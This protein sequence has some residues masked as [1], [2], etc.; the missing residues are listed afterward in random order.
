MPAKTKSP[1][2]HAAQNSTFRRSRSARWKIALISAKA[3]FCTSA[4]ALQS[5]HPKLTPYA[6]CHLRQLHFTRTVDNSDHLTLLH[7]SAPIR[8]ITNMTN[9]ELRLQAQ[10]GGDQIR[11]ICTP[12]ML[13]QS[14][15]WGLK[16]VL[17]YVQQ[18]WHFWQSTVNGQTAGI[19]KTFLSFTRR[20]M[21]TAHLNKVVTYCCCC[22]SSKPQQTEVNSKLK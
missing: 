7:P 1:L 19:R 5:K 15:S 17:E 10:Y 8:W 3:F 11:H 13:C 21:T 4:L 22:C 16:L 2:N 14:S 18:L 12:D 6:Q 20:L 9:T